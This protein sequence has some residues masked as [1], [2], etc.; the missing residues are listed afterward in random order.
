MSHPVLTVSP[1]VSL[2]LAASQMA[3]AQV[4]CLAVGDENHLEGIITERDVTRAYAAINDQSL[5]MQVG[6]FMT[7]VVYTLNEDATCT[8]AITLLERYN[9]RRILITN[10]SGT[11]R[12][13]VT[14]SDLLRAHA[15]EVE[16]Q[17]TV[18]EDRVAERTQELEML[19]TTLKN[20][21]RID[22][23]LDI[24]NRRAMDEALSQL[25]EQVLRYKKPY[26]VALIDVDFF[27]AFN[28]NYGHGAGDE[29]LKHI[30]R[31]MKK[32]IRGAD[33]V[34]R[35]G[36]DEFLAL[37]LEVSGED[38]LIVAER[39]RCN[40][41]S[42][43]LTHRLSLQGRVTVSIGV[44]DNVTFPGAQDI[45]LTGADEALYAAKNN[46]RNRTELATRTLSSWSPNNC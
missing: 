6:E 17:K 43:D 40:I 11:L 19:T 1:D 26:A 2:S 14:Q 5:T 27:K 32:T 29:V 18:L 36:G 34:Y 33:S 39:L 7:S 24:G 21:A 20:L 10:A 3:D 16:L 31:T 38:A 30:S 13:V 15:K 44:A 28:D 12:G 8:D 23:M 4:S 42:L 46:G 22:P 9:I 45:L 25:E 37:F 41:E 35:Y